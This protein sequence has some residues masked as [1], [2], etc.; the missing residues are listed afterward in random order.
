MYGLRTAMPFVM[1]MAR[2]D[3]KEFALLDFVGALLWALIF[4]L[5]GKLIGNVMGGIF[6]DVK[7]HELAIALG[8][9]LVG[10]CFWLYQRYRD[11]I[12]ADIDHA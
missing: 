9:V 3:P 8:I 2:F 5:A 1:G 10:I 11:R 4:G 6:E 7:E 12:Q